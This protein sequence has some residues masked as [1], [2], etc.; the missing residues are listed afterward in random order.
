M[1]SLSTSQVVSRLKNELLLPF[2]I[3][4][5]RLGTVFSVLGVSPL[6]ECVFLGARDAGDVDF[7]KDAAGFVHCEL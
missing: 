3:L 6:S 1:A 5:E 4:V 2:D 7:L